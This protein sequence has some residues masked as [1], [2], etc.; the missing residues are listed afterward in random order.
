MSK[1]EKTWKELTMAA[2]S[3]KSS[4]SF[5]TGD[6]KTFMP[7]CDLEKCVN[8]LTC[9]IFCPEGTIYWK[10]DFE[11]VKFNL[12]FCKGCGICANECPTKAI[13]MKIPEKE[14]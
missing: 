12:A 5:L 10:P 14:E 1:Q 7:C 3:S 11:N 13:T 4:N 2:I 8:C 9:V 6:W